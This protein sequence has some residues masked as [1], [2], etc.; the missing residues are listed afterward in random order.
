M[1]PHNSHWLTNKRSLLPRLLDQLNAAVSEEWL[2][3]YQYWTCARLVTGDNVEA[4]RAELEASAEDEKRHASLLADRIIALGGI[5]PTTPQEWYRYAR[6]T[7][8][9]P[10]RFTAEYLLRITMIGEE[11]ARRRYETIVNITRGSDFETHAL[12][13]RLLAEEELHLATL[14]ALL[15]GESTSRT[16]PAHAS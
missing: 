16:A 11:C 8:D 2:S 12:A 14:V 13:Q 7:Y 15:K 5:P 1:A 4:I 6:C 9:T 10:T 3:Y